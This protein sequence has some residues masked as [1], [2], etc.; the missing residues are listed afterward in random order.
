MK[1]KPDVRAFLDAGEQESATPA[2]PQASPSPAAQGAQGQGVT[3]TLAPPRQRVQK[4]FRLRWDISAALKVAAIQES[5]REDRRVSETEIVER[6]L[7][8]HFGIK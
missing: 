7:K 5:E 4:I 2:A 8:K 6:I 1:D 3:V